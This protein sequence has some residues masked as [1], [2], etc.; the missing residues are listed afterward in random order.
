M[1]SN[2]VTCSTQRP[3]TQNGFHAL[4]GVIVH[5]LIHGM[6][7]PGHVFEGDHPDFPDARWELPGS[8]TAG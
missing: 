6:G 2:L 4:Y 8:W 1:I 3:C 7:L 5:E